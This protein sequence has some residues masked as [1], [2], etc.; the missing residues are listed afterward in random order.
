MARILV[1]DDEPLVLNTMAALLTEEGYAVDTATSGIAALQSVDRQ[2][3]DL[4]L[5]D[6]R[7]PPPNGFDLCRILKS[8][9]DTRLVPIVLMTGLSDEDRRIRALEA[10]ADDLLGKPVNIWELSVRVRNL[11]RL[12]DIIGELER[13]E[14]V[15]TTLAL[16]IEEKD[17][18]TEGH[19]QRLAA[20]SYALAERINLDE[21]DLRAIHLGAYLHDLGKIAVPESIL[22]KPG[23]LDPEEWDVMRKHPEVGENICLPLRSF[24]RVRP[25]IRHHHERM[26]G[27]GYPDHLRG[28]EIPIG[29]RILS[30]VDVF[31]ALS[32]DRPYRTALSLEESLQIMNDEARRGW[33][34]AR[35]LDEFCGMMDGM[36]LPGM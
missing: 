2:V 36:R 3:P 17:K 26:D 11:L 31:D 28:D 1:I 14:D 25:I 12:T 8:R 27:S 13:V 34:D 18:Y 24:A 16:A 4:I 35:L 7:I 21:A 19:C 23:K 5:A 33:W 6:V 10:G 29:A 30:I 20:Y 9:A 32:T 22:L 15:M